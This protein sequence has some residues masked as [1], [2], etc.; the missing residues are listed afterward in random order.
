SNGSQVCRF[1]PTRRRSQ[2]AERVSPMSTSTHPVAPEDVM[3][4]RDG[5]LSADR[6]E[7]VLS[8]IKDCPDCGKTA[9]SLGTVSASLAKWKVTNI[10][11]YIESNLL[12]SH[13]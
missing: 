7:H 6:V 9:D 5:E 11:T 2:R 3:A 12:A 13:I 10:S 1:G 4:F 8:H